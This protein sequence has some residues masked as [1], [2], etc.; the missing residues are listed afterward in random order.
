MLDRAFRPIAGEAAVE[1]FRQ[2]VTAM[3]TQLVM[4]GLLCA[5]Q[6]DAQEVIG[7][8]GDVV[9]DG[10]NTMSFTLGE[11]AIATLSSGSLILTQGFQQPWADI[12]TSFTSL[13]T[14]LDLRVYPTPARG[15]LY[16]AGGTSLV[17]PHYAL[18]DALGRVVIRGVIRD[19]RTVV[20]VSGLAAG[21]YALNVNAPTGVPVKTFKLHI[22]R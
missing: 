20:D 4:G 19:E 15:E 2:Q 14:G 21:N 6:V 12:S 16:I 10:L 18:M 22:I 5:L 13:P 9:T 1:F 11:P 17:H 7:A 3:R 8:A